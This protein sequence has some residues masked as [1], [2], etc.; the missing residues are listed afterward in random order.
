MSA[1]G[2]R[3]LL[4]GWL[5]ACSAAQGGPEPADPPFWP[6][7]VASR[8]GRAAERSGSTALVVIQGGDAVFEWGAV[9]RRFNG[10][11]L[12]KSLLNALLGVAVER[13]LLDLDRPVG[14]FD[15]PGGGE[16]NEV[17]RSATVRHLLMSRSGI[18]L[19]AANETPAAIFARPRRN[20]HGPGE[21]WYYNN[22]DFNALGVILEKSTGLGIGEAFHRWIAVPIGMKDFRPGDVSYESWLGSAHPAYPFWISARDLAAFGWLYAREG[23][24]GD[25]AVIPRA[26]VRASTRSYSETG[27]SGYGF[28]WWVESGGR[29]CVPG[30]EFPPGSFMGVGLGGQVLV[31]VPACRL[32]VAHLVDTGRSTFERLRWLVLGDPVEPEELVAVLRPIFR[33]AACPGEDSGLG[34]NGLLDR[35]LG[36]RE[37]GES[38]VR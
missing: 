34:S 14:S 22:W 9:S 36:Y 11:S 33:Q 19:R 10:H 37:H 25:S 7:E 16:L 6:E 4:L 26:W 31:V 21:Y 32:V 8:I 2:R 20:A 17:E 3:G 18:Y 27:A 28:L 38:F 23:R 30:M 13:G 15:L 1:A 12:R 35:S 5:L 24:W 29:L